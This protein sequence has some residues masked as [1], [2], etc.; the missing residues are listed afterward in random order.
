MKLPPNLEENVLVQNQV[1]KIALLKED[2]EKYQQLLKDV[3]VQLK[4][5]E[6]ATARLTSSLTPT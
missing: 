2:L 4:K 3:N 5:A 1:K 6:E